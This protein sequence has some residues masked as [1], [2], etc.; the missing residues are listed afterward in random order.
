M[1]IRLIQSLALLPLVVATVAGCDERPRSWDRERAILG[2]LELDERVAYV[3]TARDLLISVDANTNDPAPR[4]YRVGRNPAFMNPTPDRKRVA[5]LTRGQEPRFEGDADEPPSLF[6]VDPQSPDNEPIGYAIGSPFDRLAISADSRFAVAYYSGSGFDPASGVFRNPNELA[7]IDLTRPPSDDN[8]TLRTV[9][10]FGSAPD[11]VVLSPS[12]VLPGDSDNEPRVYAVVLAPGSLT[13]LDVSRPSEREISIRLDQGTERVV[14]RELVFAPN[15]ASIYVRSDNAGDVLAVELSYD[16]PGDDPRDNTFA[17]TVAELGAGGG[18]ADIAVYDSPAGRR[19]I[20]AAIP[21][22]RDFVVVDADT[23]EFA[24]IDTAEPVDRIELFGNRALL[25]STTSGARRVESIAL[26]SLDDDLAPLDLQSV[27]VG[28]PLVDVVAIPAVDQALLVHDSDRTLLGML[29]L[30]IGSV[31]PVEGIGRLR[32]FDIAEDGTFL[33]GITDVSDRVGVLDLLS[34]HPS[35]T[36]LDAP[37]ARV[38]A[39]GNGAVFIHHDDP[40]GL[41]TILPGP[42]ARRSDAA[43]LRGFLLSDLLDQDF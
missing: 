2:P 17:A 12:M 43:V 4:G 33:V 32:A 22:A 6:L 27:D 37:A 34:L 15:S 24:T 9:R 14:P 20:L 26:D 29:D 8:P 21:S 42:G 10:S 38:F 5:V 19:Y 13:L 39:L 30:T 31:A 35:D 23:A 28:A 18:P 36:R 3:D 11:G 40:A 7:I 1:P 25:A 41:A 16:P